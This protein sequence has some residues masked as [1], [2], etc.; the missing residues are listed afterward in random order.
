MDPD[1]D[2]RIYFAAER[3]L[4]AWLRTGIAVIGLGFLVARFGVFLMMVRGQLVEHT[5]VATSLIG[6][7]FVLLGAIM[8]A[9]A[10][11]QHV[12]FSRTLPRQ[13]L[14]RRYSTALS[15]V[16]SALVAVSALV[17]AIYLA[18]SVNDV[19]SVQPTHESGPRGTSPD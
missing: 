16:T 2:P 11:W 1:H 15:L 5:H 10:T 4:L 14:P 8:I 19:H 3:T 9:A 13:E 7:S 17:L 6:I 12:T 18:V